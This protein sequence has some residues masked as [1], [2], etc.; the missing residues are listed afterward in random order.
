MRVDVRVVRHEIVTYRRGR[1]RTIPRG[2]LLSASLPEGPRLG[3][4]SRKPDLARE[5]S[6]RE[7]LPC[8]EGHTESCLNREPA[9]AARQADLR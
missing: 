8:E 2:S 3:L 5:R 7:A 4:V 6:E 9:T 1:R